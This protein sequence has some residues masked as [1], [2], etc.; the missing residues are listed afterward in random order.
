MLKKVEISILVLLFVFAFYCALIIGSSW[1]EI[2]EMNIGKERLKYLF[3]FG[4]YKDFDFYNSRFYPGFYNT[5]A[6]FVTKMFPL[7]YEIEVW[8]L[9]NCFFSILTIFG[10]YKISSQLFNKKAGK[11]IFLLCFLNPIFFGHMAMNVKDPLVAF[12]HVWSTYILLRYLKHQSSENNCY[13]YVFLV[14]LTIGLGTGVRLPF[15]ITLIPLYLFA[16]IDILLL[17]KITN[18]KFSFRKFIF[19]SLIVFLITYFITISFWPHVHTNIFTEPFK[20]FFTGID[21]SFGVTS[22]LFNGNI[23]ETNKLPNSYL[24]TN[25]FYKTPEFILICYL[26]FIFFIITQKNFFLAKFSFFWNKLLL[27]LFIFLF[28]IILFTFVPYRVYDGLRLFIYTI[29]YFTIIPGLTIYYLV[30][31]L[32]SLINKILSGLIVCLF[33]YYLAIFISFTP[34]QYTYLNKFV[35]NL[36]NAH[37]KFENDYWAVSIKELVNQIPNN[38]DLLNNKELKLAFCGAAD[39]NV[40]L[41]LKKIKNFQFKQVNWLTEDYDYIIMTNRVIEANKNEGGSDTDNLTG[42]KT[43]FDKFKGID[44]ITV[45]R[46]GLILS[47]L[48]ERR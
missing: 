33:V 22:I 43:C 31:N 2:F 30:T 27:I 23:F 48:R 17:K 38:K 24:I 28:P 26:I 9:I 32:N 3:S 36:S 39:D 14:G 20:L 46:N 18:Q 40:K 21:E 10:I 42:V 7:K 1:D 5:L 13:R 45:S 25:F 15:V 8:H 16:L 6:I 41:Y 19:H 12:A 35:G 44:I 4:S 11:I 47:T 29:P 34:Y 37:N